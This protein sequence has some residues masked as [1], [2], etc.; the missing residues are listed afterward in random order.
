MASEGEQLRHALL[1]L[2]HGTAPEV[3]SVIEVQGVNLYLSV[4]A[5]C[6]CVCVCVCVVCVFVYVL[7]VHVS[8]CIVWVA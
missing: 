1:R 7:C 2:A 5:V 8:V 4:L 6:V 3:V